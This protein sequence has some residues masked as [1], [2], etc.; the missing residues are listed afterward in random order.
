MPWKAPLNPS[1]ETCAH[2][3]NEY[4]DYCDCELSDDEKEAFADPA[5]DFEP[6]SSA[7][8]ATPLN[9][10]EGFSESCAFCGS[11]ECDHFSA[12]QWVCDDCYYSHLSDEDN[13]W[14]E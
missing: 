4:L 9:H 7:I 5:I 13:P 14:G 6:T 3:V 12:G 11:S 2:C 10:Q 1:Y 8:W